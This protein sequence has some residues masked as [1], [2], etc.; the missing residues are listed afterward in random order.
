MG[1]DGQ[2]CA[3]EKGRPFWDR[4]TVGQREELALGWGGGQGALGLG[5]DPGFTL[6]VHRV[7]EYRTLRGWGG[8]GVD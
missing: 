5:E 4:G 6:K 1:A 8:V 3:R 2:H 7:P